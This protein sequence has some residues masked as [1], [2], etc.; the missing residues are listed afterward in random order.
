LKRNGSYFEQIK[1]I[2]SKFVIF[3]DVGDRRAWLINGASALLHLVRASLEDDRKSK[4]GSKLL[5]QLDKLK[6]PTCEYASDSAVE[7]LID[8]QNMELPIFPHKREISEEIS[9]E[10]S[11]SPKQ[12]NKTK[13]THVLLQDRVEQ[14][15]HFLEQ[16]L[17]YQVDRAGQPGLEAR[18]RPRNYL[19]GFDFMDVATGA[20]PILLKITDLQST[21]KCWIDFTRAIHAVTQFGRGFG[22]LIR[23]QAPNTPCGF[24]SQMPKEADHLAVCIPDLKSIIRT[25]GDWEAIPVRVVGDI[26]WHNPDKLFERCQCHSLS[27]NRC[28]RA[29]V[30]LPSIPNFQRLA[31]GIVSPVLGGDNDQGA[32]IFGH[33]RKL[34]VHWSN[35]SSKNP[36]EMSLRTTLHNTEQE[37]MKNPSSANELLA[38]PSFVSTSSI[39][40]E[41]H[42]TQ[43]DDLGWPVSTL[44]TS[45][46][47]SST[48][49]SSRFRQGVTTESQYEDSSIMR[50]TRNFFLGKVWSS[51]N[52]KR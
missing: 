8:Q 24:W 30:L 1:D 5:F 15:Y 26:R 22:E 31:N 51:R 17:T 52:R 49:S 18:Y 9:T 19:E 43:S 50:R 29:Q 4:I 13:E 45:I 28:D 7:I 44:Q 48:E 2:S 27:H 39:S 40:Q 12:V 21:G 11:D 33:S 37:G 42:I 35:E 16:I 25:R 23:P 41:G 10:A 46:P 38:P 3:Y 20:D 36:E 14:I 6:R 32:V 34:Q 47:T